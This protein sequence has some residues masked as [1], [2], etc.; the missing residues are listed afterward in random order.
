[1]IQE[2]LALCDITEKC[3]VNRVAKA[4]LWREMENKLVISGK[5]SVL[6]IE[7]FRKCVCYFAKVHSK[8][9]TTCVRVLCCVCV[10]TK[11][12]WQLM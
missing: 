3:N 6:A 2:R 4:E 12:I 9:K 10:C 1:M 5:I 8:T 7:V 11:I